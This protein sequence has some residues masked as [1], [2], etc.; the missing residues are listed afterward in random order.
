MFGFQSDGRADLID[1]LAVGFIIM[2][3]ILFSVGAL[4]ALFFKGSLSLPF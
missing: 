4:V 2:L 1:R 3:A